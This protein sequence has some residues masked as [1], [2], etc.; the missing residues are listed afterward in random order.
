MRRVWPSMLTSA[1]ADERPRPEIQ[2]VGKY[3]ADSV[4]FLRFNMARPSHPPE[5][6]DHVVRRS[7]EEH[8]ARIPVHETEDGA[9]RSIAASRG[10]GRLRDVLD[11]IPSHGVHSGSRDLDAPGTVPDRPNGGFQ[12][13]GAIIQGTWTTTPG[14]DVLV[15]ESAP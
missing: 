1:F 14:V 5:G 6:R 4:R 2:P 13:F 12:A 7:A 9:S 10:V 15:R 8:P 11:S 3:K